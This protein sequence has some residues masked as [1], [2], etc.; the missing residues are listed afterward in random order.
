MILYKTPDVKSEVDALMARRG[1][2]TQQRSP[3]LKGL[4]PVTDHL[5]DTCQ[6]NSQKHAW[7]TPECPRSY[8]GYETCESIEFDL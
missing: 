6:R 7:Y 1:A 8:D 4:D 5:H 3:Y 2:I